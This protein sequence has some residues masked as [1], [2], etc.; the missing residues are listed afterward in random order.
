ML[1]PQLFLFMTNDQCNSLRYGNS[2]LFV[3][4][5]TKYIIGRNL[6]FLKQEMQADLVNLSKWLHTNNVVLNIKK[7]K[8][9]GD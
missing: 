5:T 4:D 1:G 7:T 8:Y 2:I 3:D 9:T 6:S